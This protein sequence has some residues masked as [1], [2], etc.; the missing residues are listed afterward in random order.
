MFLVVGRAAR[1]VVAWTLYPALVAG[2][3]LVTD[4]AVLHRGASQMLV[5]ASV[6]A[7]ISLVVHLL[8]RAI[9]HRADWRRSHGD[10]VTDVCHFIFSGGA[11][12]LA[13]IAT[14]L[15]VAA[16]AT[17]LIGTWLWPVQWPLALQVLL[18]VVLYELGGYWLHRL[19]HERGLLWRLHAV[20]HSAPRLYWLTSARNHP[21][22]LAVS[23]ALSITPLV[24]LGATDE[25][26][27]LLGTLVLATS[28]LQHAN[29][30]ISVG[31]LDR[32]LN[33]VGVH[34]HH[35]A[36]DIG[37]ANAN[38]GGMLLLWDHVFGTYRRFATMVC[39]QQESV[40]LPH[41]FP[42]DYLGQLA[43]PFRAPP[44]SAPRP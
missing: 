18:A 29:L 8:E 17:R 19:Q 38:Y 13:Q 12:Q 24:L 30:E 16:L 1:M 44:R 32:I 34:R 14:V 6:V 42:T 7:A 37:E 22:D 10:I 26:L 35:H 2:A 36:L 3:V 11:A 40:G 4:L 43:S 41:E 9:P 33:V 28:M 20:H 21:L 31:P 5:A 39:N 25:V 27:L 15:G 23:F